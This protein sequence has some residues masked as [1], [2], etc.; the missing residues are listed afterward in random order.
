MN[1]WSV[2]RVFDFFWWFRFGF[3]RGNGCGWFFC[4]YLDRGVRV[5]QPSGV[6]FIGGRSWGKLHRK[7]RRKPSREATCPLLEASGQ[8]EASGLV[9]RGVKTK[10]VDF[11]RMITDL[12]L[13][14]QSLSKAFWVFKR[15]FPCALRCWSLRGS[16]ENKSK[17]LLGL[18]LLS[19]TCLSSLFWLQ[20]CFNQSKQ[21]FFFYQNQGQTGSR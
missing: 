1:C 8:S 3:G 7:G 14:S 5:V 17:A 12:L 16:L 18:V 15:V 2:S 21:Q 11:W 20:T 6:L 13:T 10:V 19:W 9:F 4:G